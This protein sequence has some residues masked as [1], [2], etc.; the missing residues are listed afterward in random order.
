MPI[1][2]T[3]NGFFP[4]K[5]SENSLNDNFFNF[6]LNGEQVSRRARRSHNPKTKKVRYPRGFLIE[7]RARVTTGKKPRIKNS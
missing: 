3:Q 5:E 2:I 6:K 1:Y 4:V 7:R